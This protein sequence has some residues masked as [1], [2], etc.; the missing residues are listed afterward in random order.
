MGSYIYI[1]IQKDTPTVPFTLSP[2]LKR[3]M[4]RGLVAILQGKTLNEAG[5][6]RAGLW[7]ESK[8]VAVDGRALDV[9]H[10]EPVRV[11][12]PDS[13]QQIGLKRQI[14]QETL[15]STQLGSRLT[16]PAALL[17]Q[18]FNLFRSDHVFEAVD[19]AFRV[20]FP[21]RA[22]ARSCGRK[23]FVL[24]D[25]DA[26]RLSILRRPVFFLHVAPEE[27]DETG[28]DHCFLSQKTQS[29]MKTK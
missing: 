26:L 14:H 24:G 12:Q 7:H 29:E 21:L 22:S 13:E 25:G 16:F 15:G 17:G 20:V 6:G 11:A 4:H 19:D 2:L 23:V 3:A 8:Y 28:A 1:Y 9:G 10:Q 18:F 27:V 5:F